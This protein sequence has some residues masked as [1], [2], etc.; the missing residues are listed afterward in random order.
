MYSTKKYL[1]GIRRSGCK[2]ENGKKWFVI[3]ELLKYYVCTTLVL[4]VLGNGSVPI[5]IYSAFFI[6][7]T[8]FISEIV[9]L[10]LLLL[11]FYSFYMIMI[12]YLFCQIVSVGKNSYIFVDACC[13]VFANNVIHRDE[14]T[15][16]HNGIPCKSISTSIIN[17]DDWVMSHRG[18]K[19]KKR[20]NLEMLKNV[21]L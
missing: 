16:P 12:W 9:T 13:K 18:L 19:Y 2:I 4:T 17:L 15:W 11:C 14:K 6:S 3:Q 5:L 20:Y 10:I 1:L 21:L 8:I 7:K